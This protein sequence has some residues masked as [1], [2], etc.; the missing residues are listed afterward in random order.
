M[1]FFAIDKEICKGMAERVGKREEWF[2]SVCNC[3]EIYR[4]QS[5][6]SDLPHRVAG[7][8]LLRA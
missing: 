6:F 2:I 3:C 1:R 4:L 7:K 8:R 5:G